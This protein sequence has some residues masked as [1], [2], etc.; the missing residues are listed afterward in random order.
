[1]ASEIHF[2]PVNMWSSVFDATLLAFLTSY[3]LFAIS[4]A[5]LKPLTN[6]DDDW[7]SVFRVSGALAG[8]LA[9]AAVFKLL[10][11]AFKFRIY[12]DIE[13]GELVPVIAEKDSEP[14]ERRKKL[15]DRRK[16]RQSRRKRSPR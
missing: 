7:K 6:Q 2:E 13:L 11:K 9:L 1:M 8:F 12:R 16:P 14:R 3:S 4:R 15:K 10:Y 5:T